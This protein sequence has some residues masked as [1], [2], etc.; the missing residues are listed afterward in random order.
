MLSAVSIGWQG[1]ERKKKMKPRNRKDSDA[2]FINLSANLIFPKISRSSKHQL[3]VCY[4]EESNAKRPVQ[5][6]GKRE[7][8]TDTQST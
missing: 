3:P 1:P 5:P 6:S 2:G 7:G 8:H 4:F